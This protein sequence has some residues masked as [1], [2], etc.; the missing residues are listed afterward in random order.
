MDIKTPVLF[1]TIKAT[2][3]N[4]DRARVWIESSDLSLYGFARGERI[5]IDIN[6]DGIVV[7]LDPSGKRKVAGRE[8]NGKSIGILDIC[9][10]LEQREAIRM[11]CERFAVYIAYGLITITPANPVRI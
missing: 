4:K 3:M 2:A 9:M 1:S 5:T 7:K 11:N 10:P 6:N 8:R